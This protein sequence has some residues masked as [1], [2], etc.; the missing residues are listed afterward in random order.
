MF[1]QFIIQLIVIVLFA[2]GIYW[3]IMKFV[4][5]KFPKT[6]S[7]LETLIHELEKKRTELK[8]IAE[9][10]ETLTAMAEIDGK[11]AKAR[12]ALAKLKQDRE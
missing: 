9:V 3:I 11:L 8:T 10:S 1:A 12:T 5:R 4:N 6:V 7:D 2:W